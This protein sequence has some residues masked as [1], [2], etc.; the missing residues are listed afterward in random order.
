MSQ[1]IE[2]PAD[3]E[4]GIPIDEL[5]PVLKEEDRDHMASDDVGK[6]DEDEEVDDDDDDHIVLMMRERL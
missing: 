2:A 1:Y 5:I 3:D 4:S 6:A